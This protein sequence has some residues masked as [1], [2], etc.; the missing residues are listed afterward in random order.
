MAGRE[1]YFFLG[2]SSSQETF[3]ITQTPFGFIAEAKQKGLKP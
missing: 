2:R 1:T 3:K